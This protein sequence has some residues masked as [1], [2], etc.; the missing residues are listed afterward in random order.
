MEL[1]EFPVELKLNNEFEGTAA[2]SI[3]EPVKRPQNDPL[4]KGVFCLFSSFFSCGL[5]LLLLIKLLNIDVVL[6]LKLILVSFSFL[7]TLLFSFLLSPKKLLLFPNND[8]FSLL[9]LSLALLSNI[10][11]VSF[12]LLLF[13]LLLNKGLKSFL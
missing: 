13:S 9:V 12:F 5:S 11:L 3:L 1:F 10:D 8:L 4:N 2:D 7:F 6:L